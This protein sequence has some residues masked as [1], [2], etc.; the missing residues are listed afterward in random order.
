MSLE[1]QPNAGALEGVPVFSRK[2]GEEKSENPKGDGVEDQETTPRVAQQT[3]TL[4]SLLVAHDTLE[5]S[6]KST[7]VWLGEG[8]GSIP[9]RVHARMV[10][11][12]YV[13]MQ[14][15]RP[16]SASDQSFV[17]AD[18][19]KLVVLPG[20]EVSQPHKK[21]VNNVITWVQCFGRYTVAMAQ[22]HPDCTVG[23]MSHMLTV[24]KAFNEA[25]HPAWRDYYEAFREKMASTGKKSWS[26]MDVTLYQEVCGSR[27]KQRS[28]PPTDRREEHKRKRPASGRQWVCWL[29][30]DGVCHI[31][32][33]KF[34][35][36]CELCRGNHPKRLCGARPGK[37]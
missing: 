7:R 36:V 16:R 1:K 8:L 31:K 17:D 6:Q 9:K 3:S 28:T 21:P 5:A 23:F 15:F 18:T 30:N 26:G 29:Y 10:K 34:P 14:D 24:L 2:G 32:G 37:A 20:F 12:E 27:P 25:E 11:W 4:L 22:H 13:D 33:C 35:H 19:E